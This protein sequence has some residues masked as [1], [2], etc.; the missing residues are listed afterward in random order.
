MADSQMIDD[1][2]LNIQ[3]RLVSLRPANLEDVPLIY[4]LRHSAR[5]KWLNPTST[6]IQVQYEY[7]KGYLSRHAAGDEIYYVI[8]DIRQSR[9]VGVT[10]VTNLRTPLR[11]GWEGLII[12]DQATPGVALDVTITIYA[13][14]FFGAG[15]T[16]CG[17]WKVLRNH[18]RVNQFHQRMNV[19]RVI[20]SDERFFV[21]EVKLED[22]RREWNRLSRQGLGTRKFLNDRYN[23]DL[24]S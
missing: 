3:S 2:L 9:D 19:A 10:R 8:H 23:Q 16:I 13:T 6:D 17:P 21:Y 14:G 5:G 20:G 18:T 11:F 24:L 12:D 7:F 1:H 15:K 4:R 22:F